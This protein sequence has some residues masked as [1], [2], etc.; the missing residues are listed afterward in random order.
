[1]IVIGAVTSLLVGRSRLVHEPA[2]IEGVVTRTSGINQFLEPIP[3]HLITASGIERRART[4][5]LR[6][7]QLEP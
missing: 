6:V 1:M 5:G 2:R 7:A 4:V 3:M